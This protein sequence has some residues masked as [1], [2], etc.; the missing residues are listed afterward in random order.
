ML[1]YGLMLVLIIISVNFWDRVIADMMH[2]QNYSGTL[3]KLLSQ[4]PA[5][6]EV[7]AAAFILSLL[8]KSYRDRFTQLCIDLIAILLIA[9]L[10]R[11]GAKAIFGRTW[12]ETWIYTESG[13]N[14]SWIA[15]GVE[16]FHPFASGLAY[17]SFPSGHAL[18]TFALATVF[19]SYFPRLGLFW[20]ACMVGVFI[21]QLGQNYHFFGDLLAGST[22]GVFIAHMVIITTQKLRTAE[23]NASKAD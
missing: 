2:A 3:L 1:G 7:I 4:V 6:L 12:P 23:H 16:G 17:N 11:I 18:F 22:L 15:N 8:I 5:L 14:P 20:L 10:V 13:N 21:G 19:W 9:S